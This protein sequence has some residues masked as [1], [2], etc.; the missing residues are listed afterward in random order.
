MINGE[1]RLMETLKKA[2]EDSFKEGFKNPYPDVWPTSKVNEARHEDAVDVRETQQE[3]LRNSQQ[4][5]DIW[6]NP[7][8][9]I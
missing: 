3:N 5:T 2:S 8:K 4:D 7:I 6:G 9:H 1:E